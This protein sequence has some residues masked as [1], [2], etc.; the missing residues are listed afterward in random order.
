MAVL[1]KIILVV[2]AGLM[3]AGFLAGCT[4]SVP[5]DGLANL[6]SRKNYVYFSGSYSE[7]LKSGTKLRLDTYAE[8]HREGVL[9]LPSEEYGITV[10]W[11]DNSLTIEPD[12]QEV[13][14]YT[15]VF[16]ERYLTLTD[17]DG[18]EYVFEESNK[19]EN[20]DE[21]GITAASDDTTE[22]VLPTADATP[23]TKM[24]NLSGPYAL[25]TKV[26]ENSVFYDS[27]KL[28][29][30]DDGTG[31]LMYS[32]YDEELIGFRRISAT[33]SEKSLTLVKDNGEFLEYDAV[34]AMNNAVG[35]MYLY[36]TDGSGNTYIF[37]DDHRV[38]L[39]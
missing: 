18:F 24:T 7:Y 2:I 38:G 13:Q 19:P 20:T 26:D 15:A 32:D 21:P 34:F 1:K 39:A 5:G 17:S 37:A 10:H 36:L 3:T 16:D 11:T 31:Y 35:K 8:D 33:W 6:T 25:M 14:E 29:L 12:D 9:F 28:E 23:S 30:E 22:T 27:D 4:R